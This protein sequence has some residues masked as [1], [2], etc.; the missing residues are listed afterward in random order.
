[1]QISSSMVIS[2]LLKIGALIGVVLVSIPA[3]A[4][5]M[6]GDRDYYNYRYDNAALAEGSQHF[7]VV[8]TYFDAFNGRSKNNSKMFSELLK[9]DVERVYRN[10]KVETC[11]LPVVYDKAADM[12]KACI[13]SLPQKP[14]L[15]ISLGEGYC[16]FEFIT[17]AVNRDSADI[18]DNDGNYRTDHT[19]EPGGPATRAFTAPVHRL[20]C[21]PHFRFENKNNILRFSLDPGRFVCNNTS[22]HLARDLNLENIPYAF[23]HVPNSDLACKNK[24][25]KI[26]QSVFDIAKSLHYLLTNSQYAVARNTTGLDQ[27]A[28][29]MPPYFTTYEQRRGFRHT[30]YSDGW[31]IKGLYDLIDDIDSK[32]ARS[33]FFS[34]QRKL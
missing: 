2:L 1:M 29:F 19:I 32:E 17:Y 23:L 4:Q 6:G 26:R 3:T 18:P 28:T 7:T 13:E 12:A 5:V 22:Y 21:L 8:F 16:E 24:W 27:A 10:I 14:D 34:R 33:L 15:V 9:K 25:S 31:C 11:E 30:E 20:F